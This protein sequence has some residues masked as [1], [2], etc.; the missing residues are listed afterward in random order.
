MATLLSAIITQARRH[1]NEP[2]EITGG[3][4]T[5]AELVSI[6][7]RG[8]RDLWR[9]TGVRSY[10]KYAFTIAT[11]VTMAANATQLSTVPA[12][13]GAVIG[14]E[15]A[16]LTDRTGPRFRAA[17]YNGAKFQLARSEAAQDPSQVGT[18]YYDVTEAGAPIAAPVILVAPKLSS[19][20]TLRLSYVPTITELTSAGTNPIPGE[21]DQALICWC[22]AWARAR[23]RE[24]RSPDPNWLALY[25]TEKQ[26]I[27]S[28]L[29]P[30][31]QDEDDE[32]DTAEGMFEAEWGN[33]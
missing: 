12:D 19:A 24:D 20:L 10:H 23:E 8:I 26:D 17:P 29:D 25:A 27:V 22:V 30:R 32:R 31:G 13:V 5:D 9:A 1:L 33:D 6:I 4:W 11:N 3:F 16:T 7:N 14:I 15:P 21:S 2:A 18:V 28:T